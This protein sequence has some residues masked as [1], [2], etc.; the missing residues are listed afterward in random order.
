[1]NAPP[2]IHVGYPKTATTW[3]QK[4]VFKTHPGLRY[5]DRHKPA[6]S[7]L[8][9][10]VSE[11]E[12]FWDDARFAE[13]TREFARG[14]TGD[15]R[16][17]ASY[18]H[19]SGTP[20][21][22]SCEAA[23]ARERLARHFPRSKIL[24]GL[25]EQSG[26][27]WSIYVQYVML[28]G[29]LRPEQF[30]ACQ[31]PATVGVDLRGFE[32][33]RFV[34]RYAE[35]FGSEQVVIYFQE[36]LASDEADTLATIWDRLGVPRHGPPG[37]GAVNPSLSAPLLLT[38]RFL[39]HFLASRINPS[40]LVPERWLTTHNVRVF[41]QRKLDPKLRKL[42][43]TRSLRPPEALK[44]AWI[45]RFRESNRRLETRLARPLPHLKK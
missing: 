44:K 22:R 33:D 42:G 16:H 34:E 26:M 13:Q 20:F 1:M 19:L 2:I 38:L 14:S 32:Y 4:H 9:D 5:F 24:I 21:T 11:P 28:G 36:D 3:L 10:V 27:L 25:R 41:L 8:F 31:W 18:E 45:D 15:Q 30:F 43:L 35:R 23:T 12:A 40:H 17:L 39:N 7:W 37:A 6:G 29:T